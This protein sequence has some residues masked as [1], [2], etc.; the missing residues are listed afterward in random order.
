M[1]IYEYKCHECGT[2]F[3][4]YLRKASSTPDG[5]PECKSANIKKLIS[6]CYGKVNDIQSIVERAS[7]AARE[8]IQALARGDEKVIEDIAGT[9]PN[10]RSKKKSE[11]T[12]GA[13]NRR[14]DK[15]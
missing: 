13:I 12:K 7:E 2:Y 10:L 1:P 3:E 14:S 15:D 11:V 8:D 9:S 4:E 5:C 6:W